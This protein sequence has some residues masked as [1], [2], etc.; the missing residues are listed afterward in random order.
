MALRLIER[1]LPEGS[2][3]AVEELRNAQWSAGDLLLTPNGHS[4]ILT[5]RYRNTVKSQPPI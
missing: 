1:V 5:V 2:L 3:P 4:S